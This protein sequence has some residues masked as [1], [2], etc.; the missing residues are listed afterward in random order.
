MPGGHPAPRSSPS[1]CALSLSGFPAGGEQEGSWRPAGLPS[2]KRKAGVAA[3][4][5]AGAPMYGRRVW[6]SRPQVLVFERQCRGRASFCF[7]GTGSPIATWRCRASVAR[8]S[9]YSIGRRPRR[10]RA[11][12]GFGLRLALWHAR[13]GRR[14]AARR[15]RRLTGS[16]R[17]ARSLAVEPWCAVG[18]ESVELSGWAASCVGRPVLRGRGGG[19]RA[20]AADGVW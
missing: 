12:R 10:A 13:A 16:S 8:E 3:A 14:F 19:P 1:G 18:A 4:R 2:R 20:L 9:A 15:L 11:P 5:R 17:A 7:A 6:C